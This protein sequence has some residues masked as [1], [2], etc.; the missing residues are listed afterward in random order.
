MI[1]VF[2]LGQWEQ[3]TTEVLS[4][5]MFYAFTGESIDLLGNVLGKCIDILLV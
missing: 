2:L 5:V 3:Q 1:T 4:S